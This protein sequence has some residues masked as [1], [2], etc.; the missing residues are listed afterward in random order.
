MTH[1]DSFTEICLTLNTQEYSEI[2]ISEIMDYTCEAVEIVSDSVIIRTNKNKDFIDSF[3][4]QMQD[5]CQFLSRINYKNITFSHTITKKHN[6]NWIDIYRR[7]IKP[8]KCGRFY[9]YPPWE[10]V[11]SKSIDSNKSDSINII[12]E[13]SLAFGTG[14]H[15]TTFM[16]IEALEKLNAKDFLNNKNLLDFGCGSGILALCANKMG[17]KV[18]L[19]DIDELAINQSKKNFNNNNAKI[20]HIWQGSIDKNPKKYDI[21]IA[22]IVAS[23]LIE[24]KHN[25]NIALNNSGILI[26]SGILDIYKDEVLSCFADFKV[27]ETKQND[28]WICI[29]LQKA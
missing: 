6:K 7:S 10:S 27:L 12:L 14:H 22:N 20:S 5:F 18:D 9:I 8:I 11:D 1:S 4:S 25:F 3:I 16:C 29:I 21:I 23:V 28:E 2:F 13:P 24:Q 17:A 19:C 15:A 26:L